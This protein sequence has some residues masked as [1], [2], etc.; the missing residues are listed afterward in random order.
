ML[1]IILAFN[2]NTA[3]SFEDCV[4]SGTEPSNA[5]RLYKVNKTSTGYSTLSPIEQKEAKGEFVFEV[6]V[7]DVRFTTYKCWDQHGNITGFDAQLITEILKDS[8]IKYVKFIPIKW[9]TQVYKGEEQ[10]SFFAQL[11][12]GNGHVA[13]AGMSITNERRGWADMVG[14]IYRAGKRLMARKDN[15]KATLDLLN[16]P[17]SGYE[18]LRGL[19]VLVQGTNIRGQFFRE[20]KKQNP[21][22]VEYATFDSNGMVN[23]LDANKLMVIEVDDYEVVNQFIDSQMNDLIMGVNV[24]LVM[25]DTG[26]TLSLLE[27]GKLDV[28]TRL[29]TGNL[30]TD[31]DLG[32]IFGLGDGIAVK[33]DNNNWKTFLERRVKS[34]VN[35]G[36]VDQLVHKWF[37]DDNSADKEWAKRQCSSLL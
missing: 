12:R 2:F 17:E 35:D 3:Q 24:D 11:N 30:S 21:D 18:K 7:E 8:N 27:E 10:L 22:L 9:E 28:E 20:L 26:S 16:I 5:A 25:V 34:L 4:D 14:P 15:L 33:K 29:I 31:P 32:S 23:N 13:I 37:K 1:F 6:L 36:T 19:S